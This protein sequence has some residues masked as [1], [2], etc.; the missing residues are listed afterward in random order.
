MFNIKRNV[1][2]GD[3]IDTNMFKKKQLEN[4]ANYI[5]NMKLVRRTKR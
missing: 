4:P 2:K 3:R 1:R 5:G